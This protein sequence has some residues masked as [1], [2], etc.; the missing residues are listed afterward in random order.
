MRRTFGALLVLIATWLIPAFAAWGQLN[1]TS[2]NTQFL[3]GELSSLDTSCT[4][5]SALDL[6][7]D[8]LDYTSDCSDGF[9]TA[10]A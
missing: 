10:V 7:P 9:S 8:F 6:L 3:Q 4:A 2:C 5:G 1:C